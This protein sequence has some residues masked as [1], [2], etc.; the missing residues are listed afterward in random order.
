MKGNYATVYSSILNFLKRN[1]P[2]RAAVLQKQYETG[3]WQGVMR[4]QLED[5]KLNEGEFEGVF[6]DCAV[7]CA[8]LGEKDQAFKYL[9]KAIEKR[10]WAVAQVKVLPNLDPLRDDTRFDELVARVGLK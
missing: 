9:N 8:Q 10:E 4:K 5:C 6:F 2:N 1:N 7:L 3:G